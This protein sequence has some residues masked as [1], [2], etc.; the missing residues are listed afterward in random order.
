MGNELQALARTIAELQEKNDS[1]EKQINTQLD[2][3]TKWYREKMDAEDRVKELEKKL[4][5]LEK[6]REKDLKRIE[7][8]EQIKTT[9]KGRVR[10]LGKELEELEAG[11][12][13]SE[14]EKIRELHAKLTDAEAD[15]DIAKN[16]CEK[17][18]N[19]ICD[20]RIKLE[21]VE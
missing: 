17:L 19:E 16:E 6:Q 18:K 2:I 7:A 8:L 9:E 4:A 13:A 5:G 21:G 15:R 1:L 10:K 14:K 12:G 11:G 3:S 20:L